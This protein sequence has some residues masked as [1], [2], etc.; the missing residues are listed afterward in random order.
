MVLRWKN[1]RWERSRP[2]SRT[3]AVRHVPFLLARSGAALDEVARWLMPRRRP[4]WMAL[5]LQRLAIG[6]ATKL[7]LYAQLR[8]AEPS[9]ELRRRWRSLVDLLLDLDPIVGKLTQLRGEKEAAVTRDLVLAA[10]T[11]SVRL[12]APALAA[13]GPAPH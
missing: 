7:D 5:A 4:E 1:K 13:S 6:A 3:G 9:P 2:S 10:I 8:A 12:S 11:P